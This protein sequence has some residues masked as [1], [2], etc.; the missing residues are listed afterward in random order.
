MPDRSDF[1]LDVRKSARGMAAIAIAFGVALGGGSA[2][3]QQAIL[4]PGN[5]AVTG[6]SGA[7]PPVQIA[8]GIDPGELTFI[9]GGGPSLRIVDLQQMGGP[10]AAQLVGAV[11]PYSWL[12]N[13]IGQV[14]G[15]AADD[16]T[17]PNIYVAATS[18]YGLPIVAPGPDGQ[19]IH[20]KVGAPNAAF[21]PGLW[22]EGGGP[23]SIWK[24]DGTT[25]QVKLFANVVL[26]SRTNSGAA[27]GGLAFDPDSKSLFV[28]DRE[29]GFIHRFAMN[30]RELGRYGHG[31]TGRQALGM[32]PAHWNVPQR[33]DITSPQFDSEQPA[34]WNYAVPE[35]RVYGLAVYQHRLYY[36]IA[37]GLQI[38]SVG[39]QADGSFDTD[40]VIEFVVPPAAGPTEISKIT[41]DE[42]GRMYL[43][44]RPAPTGA[45]D[46]ETLTQPGI[47]RVLRY[48]LVSPVG[49]RVWQ[50]VPDSYA[51][52]FP[53]ALHNGNGGAA[54]GYRYDTGGTLSSQSCGGF[55][56][57]TGEDLRDSSDTALAQWLEKTGPLHVNGLQGNLTWS[58]D[59]VPPLY[60][61]FV[62]YG[63]EIGDAYSRGYLGDIA[64]VPACAP[65]LPGQGALSPLPLGGQPAEIAP[66][67]APPNSPPAPPN[68]PPTPP[69]T[70]PPPPNTP[71]S[72]AC[73]SGNCPTGTPVL[74]L[75]GQGRNSAGTCATCAVPSVRIGDQCCS[76][77]DLA[78]GGRCVKNNPG[79]AAGE[80]P[81]GPSNACCPSGQIYSSANGAQACCLSG[82][83]AN[84]QCV[85]PPA[86]PDCSPGSTDPRCCSKGYVSTGK[87]CCLAGQMTSA[88]TCCPS[89]QIPGGANKNQ[90]IPIVHVPV[91]P[92]CCATGQVPAKGGTCC[93]TANVTTGGVCCSGPVDPRNR[94]AC[95][96]VSH[97]TSACAPGYTKMPD[98]SCCN[99]RSVGSDG[100]SCGVGQQQSCAPGTFRDS[101]GACQT[102]PTSACPPGRAPNSDGTCMPSQTAACP[103]GEERDRDG[104]CVTARQTAC[105]SGEVRNARGECVSV[106]PPP[107]VVGRVA[108]PNPGKPPTAPSG[109]RQ[110]GPLTA[111]PRAPVFRAPTGGRGL[112]H[113]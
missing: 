91:G 11:K 59:D 61:Y 16:A 25:G 96:A 58:I 13:Q 5:A 15:V 53:L 26:G 104:G 27:L 112:F 89:G 4:A 29:T 95:P 12:A 100:K 62:A 85:P 90:C 107:S 86:N 39:L 99:N 69:N 20:I 98:G 43:A 93:P 35:R 52:G 68:T 70:P 19:P 113:R 18:A 9:D 74:C 47:G 105:R 2:L 75:P 24:I 30:G 23:G 97:P 32:P 103:A 111:T 45:Y 41:F 110:R 87:S 48:A 37:D 94:T 64:I 28:S 56:W 14:F 66:T 55:L 73:P 50:G 80:T 78:P 101:S 81:V 44:E 10:P 82:R 76:P 108:H 33:I 8:P 84:G 1:L 31:V 3:A 92:Q 51:I 109:F 54:I 67:T 36:A 21:M 106:G 49:P 40:A 83:V 7:P 79:C 57:S 22:G 65:T 60:S 72:G 17:P 88:G 77:A 38:W 6:F 71:P 46:F 34:T 102:I 63:D 42:Q